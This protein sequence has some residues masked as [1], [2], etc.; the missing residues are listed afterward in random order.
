MSL[1]PIPLFDREGVVDWVATHLDGLY[2]GSAVASP[3]FVGGQI[4]ADEALAGY[5]V[6]GY[7]ATRNDVWPDSRQGASR[8]SPYIRHN[9]ISLREAWCAVDGGPSCDV[10]K[11]R[12]E[13]MWQE[14]ARH[15]YARLGPATGKGLRAHLDGDF[16]HNGWPRARL[17]PFPHGARLS[18]DHQEPR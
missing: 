8:L 5:D 14:Y 18:R 13:L 6:S 1:L 16:G 17:R 7:T 3:L 15:L 10:S 11:F 2:S 9:L 12:D 4:A